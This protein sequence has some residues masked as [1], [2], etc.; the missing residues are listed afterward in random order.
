MR[1][2]TLALSAC[3]A[4]CFAAGPVAA[5][6][7]PPG[8]TFTVATGLITDQ[9][10]VFATVESAHVVPARTRLAGTIVSLSVRDGDAVTAGQTIA[11]VADSAMAQQLQSLNA[12]ITG[13][14][15]QLA[16]A[17]IDLARAQRL[18]G[19]G[20]IA[21]ATLDQAQ[22]A[23]NVASSSLKSQIAARNALAAQIANG[24]VL[25]PVSGRVL[26]RPVTQGSVVVTGDTIATIAEQDYVLRLEVPE[27]HSRIMHVGDLVRISDTGNTPEF[28]KITLI[29]PQIQNGDVQADATSPG[30]GDYFVGQRIQVWISAG[31]RP[32][33]VIPAS[34]IESR[35]GLDYVELKT[36]NGHSI[37]VPVQQGAPHPTPSMP[38][39]V[40]ILSGLQPGNVLTAPAA[41]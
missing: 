27:Y 33:L 35:F 25:A 7:A 31:Q 16:Q 11:T 14:R 20:A 9:K 3:I 28:G 30:L 32:G 6:A 13:L 12:S 22:T 26:H 5:I 24:A 36:P 40:E 10:A 18:I 2:S 39:G 19:S 15:A 41:P 23:Q 38:D 8:A 1:L 34:F 37:A 4:A 17:S 29:Y 21:R